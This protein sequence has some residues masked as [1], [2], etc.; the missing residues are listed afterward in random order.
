MFLRENRCAFPHS[1]G[2]KPGD[3]NALLL[4]TVLSPA[5]FQKTVSLL[6]VVAWVEYALKPDGPLTLL[7]RALQASR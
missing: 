7:G 6:F 4:K 3:K 1:P 2:L 5:Q